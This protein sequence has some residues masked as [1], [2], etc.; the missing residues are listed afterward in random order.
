MSSLYKK[1]I[2][3]FAFILYF[4]ITL[5]KTLSVSFHYLHLVAKIPIQQDLIFANWTQMKVLVKIAINAGT[6]MRLEAHVHCS[7]GAGAQGT[8]NHLNNIPLYKVKKNVV[9]SIY[10]N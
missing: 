6:I 2:Y 3:M 1:S 10:K 9:E 4:N 5:C 7:I 8:G